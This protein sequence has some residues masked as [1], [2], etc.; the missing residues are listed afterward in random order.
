MQKYMTLMNIKL[1]NVISDILGKSG[2]DIISAI[3]GGE[4]NPK[5]LAALADP[6]CKAT[7]EEIEKSLEANWDFLCSNSVLTCIITSKSR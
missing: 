1:G 6:R 2:Q 4:R 5:V 7:P 3:M